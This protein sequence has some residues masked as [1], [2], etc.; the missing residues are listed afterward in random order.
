[1][2]SVD[3]PSIRQRFR[4]VGC[5]RLYAKFL[6]PNDNSKNQVYLGKSFD[7]LQQLPNR[8]IHPDT[9]T[10]K[11]NYKA[12]LDFG[13]ITATGEVARAPTATLILYPEY[14]EVRFSGF[15]KGCE[16]PPSTLMVSRA[17]G[18][19]LLLGV[20]GSSVV[21]EVLPEDSPA[22]R[23]LRAILGDRE[24]PV[25]AELDLVGQGVASVDSRQ[26]ELQCPLGVAN[27]GNLGIHLGELLGG[28]DV[29]AKN[30][31]EG[32]HGLLHVLKIICPFS[33]RGHAAVR[34]QGD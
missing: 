15:L 31:L 23:E 21:G 10:G 2:A 30:R 8:G 11:Q 4:S 28:L 33:T 19:I 3:L 13:W 5:E 24:L 1:M 9:R 14:P 7:V 26:V 29:L 22:A 18:R 27:L 34:C 6:A 32:L 20:A 16:E 12:Q 25:L 17:P